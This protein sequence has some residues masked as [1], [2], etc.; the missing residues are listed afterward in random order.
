MDSGSVETA[1]IT[2]EFLCNVETLQGLAYVLSMLEYW[3]RGCPSLHKGGKPWFM[4]LRM[5]SSFVKQTHTHCNIVTFINHARPKSSCHVYM[6]LLIAT[7]QPNCGRS[8]GPME[9][10]PTTFQNGLNWWIFA[11]LWCS[12]LWRMNTLS[13]I[14]PLW[15]QNSKINWLFLWTLWSTCMFKI[16]IP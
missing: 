13:S 6:L 14:C 11:W 7:Q 10:W 16:L 12:I 5:L 1:K 3:C 8:F 15:N 9:F 4:I 2:R